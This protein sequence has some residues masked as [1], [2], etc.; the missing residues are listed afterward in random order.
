MGDYNMTITSFEM[1]STLPTS[2]YESVFW[3]IES[4][5][6]RMQKS[7]NGVKVKVQKKGLASIPSAFTA[8]DL[9]S[10]LK[11]NLNTED[12]NEAQ[13]LANLL[14][15]YGYLIPIGESKS[16][17]FKDENSLYRFQT[18]YYWPSQN[19]APN[20]VDY[21]IYL[22]KKSLRSKQK[23]LEEAEQEILDKIKKL[24]LE[25]WEF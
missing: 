17:N 7:E 11:I 20:D 22:V 10:W 21:A 19:W 2:P 24:L 8:S 25:K 1:D 5:L 16:N 4:L 9:V 6:E 23:G 13:N 18:P 15:S 3:K 14:L 12:N